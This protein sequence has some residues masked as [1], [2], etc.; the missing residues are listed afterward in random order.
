MVLVM[1]SGVMQLFHWEWFQQLIGYFESNP[2]SDSAWQKQYLKRAA[3][4]QHSSKS[5]AGRHQY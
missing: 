1:C 4:K 3:N 2:L 5:V